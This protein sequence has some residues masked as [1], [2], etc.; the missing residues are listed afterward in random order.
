MSDKMTSHGKE[1]SEAEGV[2]R[3]PPRKFLK[4]LLNAIQLKMRTHEILSQGLDPD[5]GIHLFYH[6]PWICNEFIHFNPCSSILIKN[7]D[8]FLF[9]N[10]GLVFKDPFDIGNDG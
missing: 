6:P 8:F 3:T 2:N 5:F 1:H 7:L 10:V 4:N 9:Q